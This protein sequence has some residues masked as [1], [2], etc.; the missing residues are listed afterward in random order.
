[1]AMAGPMPAP[2]SWMRIAMPYRISRNAYADIYGPT[3][4]DRVRLGD[5]SLMLE[6]ERDLTIYG[7]ECK[8]GGGK[9]LR[10]GMGQATGVSQAD[11]LDVVITNALIVD[12][13]GIYKADVGIKN[14]RI[15][16][17]GKAGNPDVMAGVSPNMI[18]GVTTEAIAG[19]GLI[20]TAGGLDVHIHYIR[21]QQA[22]DAHA[23]GLTTLAGGGTG[24]AT[25]T[26]ATSCSPGARHVELML[27]ST[28]ALPLNF[29]FTGKGNTAKPEGLAE[30][31][32]GGAVGLKLHEDWG[33]TPAA[34]DCC[35]SVADQFDVQVTIH[36]DT[37]NESGFVE[38]SVAAFK[39]RTIHT[40]HTE[41]AGG[42]HAPDIIKVCAE[43]NV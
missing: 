35:L 40:Y 5:T 9:V 17:I 29:A 36:T 4:G 43:P 20:L 31:I 33:T 18:V 11:A 6:V 25:G 14:G 28:D 38:Q 21:P 22:Y 32:I 30:Q 1:M 41:G 8:F 13:S 3:T 16:G 26:C 42:G 15:A 19:E 24:P 23:S 10:D 7:D 39:G 27:Q 37:L 12:Y 2:C 34:I